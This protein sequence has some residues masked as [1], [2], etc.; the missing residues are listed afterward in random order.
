MLQISISIKKIVY[1]TGKDGKKYEE[2]YD[3]LV[4]STGS[5]PIDL[6]IVGKELENVQY[7]KLFQNAQEVIDK[8]NVNKSIEK[9][10]CCWSRIYR[11]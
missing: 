2:S 5:L 4:L 6:P 9:S 7:V 10:C 3:K 8:L 11:S 1:A